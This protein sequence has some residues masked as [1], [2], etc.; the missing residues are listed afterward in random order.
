MKQ[1]QFLKAMQ[2]R[3]ACKEF[4]PAMKIPA[5]EFEFILEAA[6]L[7]P[8]SFGF[9][10]WHFL[11]VQTPELRQKLVPL[12]W[13]GQKQIPTA[14]HLVIALVKKG[15]FMRFDRK[16]IAEFMR[17]VQKLPPEIQKLKGDFYRKFQETDFDL[18]SS[19]RALTDWAAHQTYLPL[20]N[21]MT[22]AAFIGVDSCPMEGF[23][24]QK[25]DQ[26]VVDTLNIDP[27][28]YSVAYMVA[29]G[30]RKNEPFPKTRQSID[31][32]TTYL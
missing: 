11:I 16:Y 32:I 20:A 23:D 1:E 27:A 6:R 12:V 5:A 31:K 9:E 24:R 29:F 30:Y 14:S 13:G 25:L 15:Y 3:H 8:S 19:D 18:L 2:F 22:A 26:F 4:D 7:S 28:Q 17:D 10:P 21:M